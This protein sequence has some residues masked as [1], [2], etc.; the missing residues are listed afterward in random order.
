L[1]VGHVKVLIEADNAYVI[2]NVTGTRSSLS[3]RGSAGCGNQA[4]MTLNARVEMTPEALERIVAE[5]VAEVCGTKITQT[6]EASKCLQPGRPNP[7]YRYD[8]VVN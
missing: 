7:T 1:A 2:G 4:K 3:I 8:Y 5:V 6:I